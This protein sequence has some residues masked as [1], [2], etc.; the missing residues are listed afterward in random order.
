MAD[1]IYYWRGLP[2][3]P[4]RPWKE[5]GPGG[6]GLWY[7]AWS[8]DGCNSTQYNA[9]GGAIPPANPRV[10]CPAGGSLELLSATSLHGPW[11]PL[12]PMFTTTKSAGRKI[13]GEFVTSNYFGVRCS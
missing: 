2:Y 13:T 1:P 3:D 4:V 8:A 6:D 10:V 11:K 12:G 9:S 5:V 7:H